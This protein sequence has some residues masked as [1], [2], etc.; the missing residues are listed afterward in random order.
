M[1]R[2][3]RAEMGPTRY[4]PD[5]NNHGKDKIIDNAARL[6]EPDGVR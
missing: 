6:P 5:H 1:Q 3:H 4:K 2:K